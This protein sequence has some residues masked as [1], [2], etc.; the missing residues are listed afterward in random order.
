ML[1]S[2]REDKQETWVLKNIYEIRNQANPYYL[3]YYVL[4]FLDNILSRITP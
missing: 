2:T 1:V 3:D 4:E